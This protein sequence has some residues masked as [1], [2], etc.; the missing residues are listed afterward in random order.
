MKI[1]YGEGLF[2][3]CTFMKAHMHLGAHS[4]MMY[5]IPGK[6]SKNPGDLAVL[7]YD[8]KLRAYIPVGVDD[9]Q[10][11][12]INGT[13][14]GKFKKDIAYNHK[15]VSGE[16]IEGE[17]HYLA[18]DA[19]TLLPVIVNVPKKFEDMK[20]VVNSEPRLIAQMDVYAL[21]KEESKELLE[22]AKNAVERIL[23]E[24]V[25]RANAAVDAEEYAERTRFV[26]ECVEA[27]KIFI[28]ACMVRDKNKQKI[29]DLSM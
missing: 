4:S 2:P 5:D 25:N 18:I 24:Q 6:V 26:E 20:K 14:P 1:K 10:G 15:L 21:T 8:E 28:N 17:E 27:A 12:A 3:Y 7:K 22:V 11:I 29:S 23:K 13:A 9:K 16:F 19:E